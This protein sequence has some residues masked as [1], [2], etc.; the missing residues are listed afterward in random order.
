MYVSGISSN[1]GACQISVDSSILLLFLLRFNIYFEGI[2]IT[3]NLTLA[4]GQIVSVSL[5]AGS[6]IFY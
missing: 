1:K 5:S 4:V 3:Q 6:C 2:E